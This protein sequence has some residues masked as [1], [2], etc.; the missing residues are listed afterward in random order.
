MP[1]C[2]EIFSFPKSLATSHVGEIFINFFVI[3]PFIKIIKTV[4]KQIS[5]QEKKRREKSK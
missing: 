2:I 3:C 5:V 1:A 4:S